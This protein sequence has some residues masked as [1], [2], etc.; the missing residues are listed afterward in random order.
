ME[1]NFDLVV[2][3]AG[4]AGY[5]AAIRAAQLGMKVACVEK[6]KT[7]GGTCL[8]VGCIPSKALLESSEIYAR[9][10]KELGDH[11][12]QVNGLS[13]DLQRF[14]GRKD[15]VV[16]RLTGGVAMLFKKNKIEPVLGAAQIH[17]DK[18][19]VV[20]DAKLSA[21][22]IILATGSVS[23]N[24]PGFDV[25]NERIVDSTGA[26]S[27]QQIPKKMIVIGGGYIGLEMGSVYSRL[28]SEVLVL[29][30][31]DRIVPMMDLELGQ[32]F[33]KIL[34]RQGIQFRLSA[35]VKKGEVHGDSVEVTFE[36]EGK[37]GKITVDVVL[38][39]VGRKP[40]TGGLGLKEAGIET[41]AKGFIAIDE[42]FQTTLS[43]V[44]AVGDCVRGPMLAHKAS[45]EGIAVVESLAGQAGHVNY[46]AIPAIVYTW[47]EVAS[48][49]MT[50]EEAK[51]KGIDYK[52]F[53]FPFLANGRALAMGYRDGFVKLIADKKTDRLL[54]AHI[55][56]PRASDMIA[57]MVLAIEFSASAEDIARTC[58]AHPTLS[59]AVK[60]AA[61]GLGSG[62]IHI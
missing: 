13:L 49:G 45:E 25:D 38:V 33:Q 57:E 6:D 14:M 41:D 59:E 43:G 55:L 29:E 42:K 50:E 26:L 18:T 23:A 9:T 20:G 3:G 47:P 35:S 36:T 60:E 34:E 54:G 24:L 2:I 31:L 52:A 16:K 37:E 7:L 8:N 28:G 61:L 48:V 40:Y 30:A 27:L 4:P 17:Q 5:V 56:G 58:H 22:N 15:Q 21:K 19:V 11:G 39:A 62:T 44:Y 32:A 46:Q 51:A 53:K 1:K 12:I 10:A